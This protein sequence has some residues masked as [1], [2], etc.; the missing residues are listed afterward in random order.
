MPNLGLTALFLIISRLSSCSLVRLP[1]NYHAILVVTYASAQQ[2]RL[3]CFSAVRELRP[4]VKV[5]NEYISGYSL[6]QLGRGVALDYVLEDVNSQEA[7]FSGL[8]S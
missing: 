8:Y 4:L 2:P 6:V 1:L 5:T 7:L 3:A